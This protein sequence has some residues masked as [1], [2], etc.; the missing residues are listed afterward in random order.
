MSGQKKKVDER[1]RHYCFTSYEVGLLPDKYSYIVYGREVCPD[2]GRK[3]LQGYVEFKDKVSFKVAQKRVG[4]E[5]CHITPRYGTPLEAS[6]YCK[7]GEQPHQEWTDMG[8]QGPNFGLNADFFE[9]GK[10][11]PGQGNRT[12]MSEIKK[13]VLEGERFITVIE[14]L[15]ENYQQL[16]FAEGLQKYKRLKERDQPAVHW[17]VGETGTGKSRSVFEE[18]DLNDL[19]RMEPNGEWFDG[20]WGQDAVLIDDFRGNIPFSILL[21]LLDRYPMQVK[22]KGGFTH[23]TP[24]RIYITSCKTPEECYYN[25]GERIDQLLRRINKIIHF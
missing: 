9:D 19:F 6:N 21:Q 4:D 1:I 18:E 16:K 20:Y 22:V 10:L 17:L 7:K 13:S 2:T 23:W 15:V 25:C 12:D 5:V 8:I 11:S 14:D 3:H 24:K